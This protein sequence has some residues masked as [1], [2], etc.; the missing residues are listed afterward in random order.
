MK[1]D[2]KAVILPKIGRVDMVER[3]RF[4]GSIR[5]VTVNR[6]ADRWLPASALR[7]DSQRHR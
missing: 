1:V 6:S 3:L 7:T 4:H 2:G 5:E